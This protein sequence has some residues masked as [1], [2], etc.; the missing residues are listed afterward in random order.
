MKAISFLFAIGC[1]ALTQCVPYEETAGGQPGSG[2]LAGVRTS[3]VG[4]TVN[5]TEASS[6][7]D[8]EGVEGAP[9]VRI[10][11]KEQRAYFYKGE[12]LVGSSP[13]STGR[14]GKKTPR[15]TFKVTQKS[16]DHKSS[17]YGVIRN[18]TTGEVVNANADTRK[19]RAGP[20]EVFEHAPMDHFLRFNGAIGMHA[21]HLPGYPAS[22]GCVRLPARMAEVYYENAPLGTP[23]I[24]E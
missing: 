8:G 5:P 14:E 7:W 2:Y 15:G 16:P 3:A 18:T 20:G 17:L 19:H 6:F 23:V 9:L 11:I 10:N 21:G 4:E 13:I 24:V 22:A 12:Q 1:F